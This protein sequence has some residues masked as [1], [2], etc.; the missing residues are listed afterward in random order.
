MHTYNLTNILQNVPF[1]IH[2]MH[3]N[4]NNNNSSNLNKFWK[5]QTA[6]TQQDDYK[7]AFY[8]PLNLSTLNFP[9]FE[10]KW[11]GHAAPHAFS[12]WTE[13]PWINKL[14]LPKPIPSR[15]QKSATPIFDVRE[16]DEAFYFDGEF[17]GVRSKDDIQPR[18]I[19]KRTLVISATITKVDLEKEWNIILNAPSYDDDKEQA[20]R[21]SFVEADVDDDLTLHRCLTNDDSSSDHS[22]SSPNAPNRKNSNSSQGSQNSSNKSQSR[23]PS[24]EG[25]KKRLSWTSKSPAATKKPQPQPTIRHLANERPTGTFTRTFTFPEDVLHASLDAKLRH[26]LLCM[27]IFKKSPMTPK[28]VA[29]HVSPDYSSSYLSSE[30]RD[31]KNG[32]VSSFPNVNTTTGQDHRNRRIRFE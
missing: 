31:V 29:I 19:N 18:W 1:A 2:I 11:H 3:L 20:P 5:T 25:L 7:M 9:E 13:D 4:N 16:T 22:I 32:L 14:H 21:D 8:A 28:P 15:K 10:W 12:H 24:L 27:I 17:P 23:R 30:K 6:F 26:G